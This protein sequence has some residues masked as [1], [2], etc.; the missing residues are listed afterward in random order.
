MSIK[1]V[2]GIHH[3]DHIWWLSTFR[4]S[5]KV[6]HMSYGSKHKHPDTGFTKSSDRIQHQILHKV[7]PRSDDSRNAS[8]AFNQKSLCHHHQHDYG[9]A[10][11][12]PFTSLQKP[13]VQT[14]WTSCRFIINDMIN[15]PSKKAN[16]S[17]IKDTNPF[18]LS[19]YPLERNTLSLAVTYHL[20]QTEW[21]T[22][23]KDA[24]SSWASKTMDWLTD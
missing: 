3:Y 8:Q 24:S 18:W 6:T 23:R 19:S 12:A 11:W 2:P 16:L 4:S 5:K 20:W 14:L 22:T 17:N 10:N 21:L 15:S 1:R 7:L 13:L 9:L